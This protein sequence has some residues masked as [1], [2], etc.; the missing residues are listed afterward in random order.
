[1]VER[2]MT[3]FEGVDAAR[4]REMAMV[5]HERRGTRSRGTWVRSW[6]RGRADDPWWTRPCVLGLL[7]LVAL[8]YLWDLGRNGWGYGIYSAAV[9]AGTKSLRA[10]LFGS[11]DA[12][13]FITL[14]K[15]P[16]ALW[17][18]EVPAKV[19]G[20]TPWTVMV[21]QAL[22][23]VGT[24]G[25]VYLA[26]RRW[27]GPSAGLVAGLVTAVTP[28]CAAIFRFNNPDALMVM[29]VT[30]AAYATVR[31][32]D[33]GGARWSLVA[34]SVVGLAFLA[35]MLE[36]F[37]V[38][39]GLA[40]AY[41]LAGPGPLGQRLRHV[42]YGGAALT[43]TAGWWVATVQLTP[44]SSRP[45]IGSTRDNS[46]LSLIFGYNGLDRF[47]VTSAAHMPGPGFLARTLRLFGT[48]MGS[49]VSWFLPAALVLMVF[50][51]VFARG[52]GRVDRTRAALV[53]WGG[54]LLVMGVVFSYSEGMV[55]AYYTVALAPAVGGLVGVGGKALWS[56]R[57]QSDALWVA[58]GSVALSALWA[59]NLLDRDGPWVPWLRET[60]LFGG[61]GAAACL[62]IWR[63]LRRHVRRA[64]ALGCVFMVLAG[65][66][67]FSLGP[68]VNPPV[69]VDPY[70]YA[71]TGGPGAAPDGP[72]GGEVAISRPSREL[73]RML[74]HRA[75]AYRWIVATIG[76]DPAAGYELATGD[77]AMAIGGWSGT[78]PVPTLARFERLVE[79]K[80]VHYFIPASSGFAAVRSNYWTD[81]NEITRWVEGT[82][83]DQ[84]ISGINVYNLT[85]QSGRS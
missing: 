35:K 54:W 58:A 51:L 85:S 55:N 52:A 36:A 43:A 11:L 30:W 22:E 5:T 44:A 49:Q 23:G 32:I 83:R 18:I 37:L 41:L 38:V 47:G 59:F 39:P 33:D 20:V 46:L 75:R 80:K 76:S 17:A 45:Y 34:G 28:V 16:A 13:N 48:E 67:A 26:V 29:L 7:C 61:L 72:G 24:V 74:V 21:P 77:A 27:S 62:L 68:V 8:L 3:V 50:G 69:G 79:L 60:I 40:G 70:A 10:A 84:T 1:M 73:V 4:E 64:V 71:P 42:A 56:R 9:E 31:A 65:P 81:A 19:F 25:A 57:G 66:C 53:L 14:D 6:F 78:D 12:A 63:Q 82:F 15:P 2:R